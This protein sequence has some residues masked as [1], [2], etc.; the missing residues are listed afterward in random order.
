[1]NAASADPIFSRRDL[2]KGGGALI[3]GFSM[4]GATG[5]ARR[6]RA[7]R[8]RGPARHERDR[9]LDRD[10]CRQHRDRLYRQGRIRPG[11]HHRSPADR[12]RR[13]R[14]R[15]E[16]GALGPARHQRDAEPGRHH[17]ELVDRARRPANPRRGSRGAAGAARPRLDP[18][19]HAGRQPRGQQGRRVDRRSSDPVGLLR[20][21]HRRQAVQREIHRHRAA[22]GDRR[23]TRWSAPTC[24]ASTSPTRRRANTP[25]CSTCACPACCTAAWCGRAA[26]APMGSAPSRW[27]S[28][29]A[30]SRTSRCASCARATSSASCAENEWDAI[31]AARALKVTWQETPALP[32]NADLFDADARRQDRGR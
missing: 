13:A 14:P 1:M 6:G 4:A 28:T 30:R 2:L 18:A 9:H 20:R 23:A 19:R 32:G 27:R 7:R 17:F 5:G 26:S 12:G 11:Q 29:R 24:R 10:P 22:E 16:P 15:H 25:T 3:I 31:S 21:A 8:R